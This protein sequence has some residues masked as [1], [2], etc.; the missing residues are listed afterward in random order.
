MAKLKSEFISRCI[1]GSSNL[2]IILDVNM[3]PQCVHMFFV[4]RSR[5]SSVVRVDST[6]DRDKE[7]ANR[8]CAQRDYQQ[9]QTQMYGSVIT[10]HIPKVHVD[11][12]RVNSVI[13]KRSHFTADGVLDVK[14]LEQESAIYLS[15]V[16]CILC[17][18]TLLG[19]SQCFIFATREQRVITT[20]MRVRS[21]SANGT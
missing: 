3:C 4:R 13:R 21:E 1:R 8:T 9:S 10:R 7:L 18:F 16:Q 20:P 19:L 6:P 15:V 14:A 12:Y 17:L 5:D 2:V 11:T